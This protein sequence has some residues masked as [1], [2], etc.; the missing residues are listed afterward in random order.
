MHHKDT[1]TAVAE[2]VPA[3]FLGAVAL[4]ATAAD[5]EVGSK[6]QHL[7]L[8]E[9]QY[10]QVRAHTST[11]A[12]QQIAAMPCAPGATASGLQLAVVLQEVASAAAA[13]AAGR[14]AV[15]GTPSSGLLTWTGISWDMR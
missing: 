13:A 14:A 8:Q 2:A 10:C 9:Q 11:A 5:L 12:A 1:T 15:K 4:V 6:Q 7:A 3:A